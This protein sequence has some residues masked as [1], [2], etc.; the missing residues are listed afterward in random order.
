MGFPPVPESPSRQLTPR[1]FSGSNRGGVNLYQND[2]D[3]EVS[4]LTSHTLGTIDSSSICVA[5]GVRSLS[6]M[7][8]EGGGKTDIPRHSKEKCD[9]SYPSEEREAP[10]QD[11]D[12]D[13]DTISA[14]ESILHNANEV[15]SR[16]GSSL[17]ARRKKLS[18]TDHGVHDNNMEERSKVE[19]KGKPSEKVVSVN[20]LPADADD[21]TNDRDEQFQAY[22]CFRVGCMD[23]NSKP[24][25]LL[26]NQIKPK[27]K[28]GNKDSQLDRN[29]PDGDNDNGGRRIQNLEVGTKQLQLL[30]KGCQAETQRANQVLQ[31]YREGNKRS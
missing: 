27:K 20:H 5:A 25:N 4:V 23:E 31:I 14:A 29:I 18:A 9:H 1:T 19:R 2:L 22:N 8:G 13:D 11:Y 16:I 15:L 21:I 30:L 28:I 24:F 26:S 10:E 12:G 3:D 7:C 6:R 17:Y